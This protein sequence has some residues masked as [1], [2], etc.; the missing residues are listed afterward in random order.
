MKHELHPSAKANLD[1][2]GNA[3]LS[4]LKFRSKTDKKRREFKPDLHIAA[5]LTEKDILS[6]G[7][8]G[9]IDMTGREKARY[10]LEENREVG[11]EGDA[12]LEF[13]RLVESIQ[14]T[15]T[16]S[17]AISQDRL[18]EV[19]F[20]WFRD[21]RRLATYATLS[22]YIYEICSR[23]IQS[24]EVA[25]PI[26]TLS[27]EMPFVVGRVEIRPLTKN[28]LDAWFQNY[29]NHAGSDEERA[30]II[31]KLDR[32]RKR[33]QGYSAAFI[34][35]N[36][37]PTRAQEV[38]L[39]ETEA[40]L[41]ILRYC[42]PGNLSSYIQCAAVP[43]GKE[44]IPRI[45]IFIFKD[46]SLQNR[47]ERM[48]NPIWPS[49]AITVDEI[50]LMRANHLDALSEMYNNPKTKFHR[51]II[52]SVLLY[53]RM[54]VA[55]ELSDK[56]VLL[57]ASL[58]SLFLRNQ[59]EPIQQNLGYRLAQIAGIEKSEKKEIVTTTLRVYNLR[60]KF[61]HH[62]Q[63]IDDVELLNKFMVYAWRAIAITISKRDHFKS[64][65]DYLE[66]IDELKFAN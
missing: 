55:L 6:V 45:G 53:S 52:D 14:R 23:D 48:V 32:M 9:M 51:Q 24:Y 56:L 65:D 29:I 33:L 64:L 35:V 10:F 17:E 27:V 20:D 66:K 22:D 41:G 43:L 36:A 28:V 3:L 4:R 15:P 42:A 40:A 19:A 8:A 57:L 1:D 5:N 7:H 12:Y 18:K 38:A 63:A 46:G 31:A 59:N 11:L 61:V 34:V 62:G 26:A 2:R 37:E 44:N 49:W 60:S 54:S 25:I 30:A 13:E 39:Q 21:S 16:F 50:R 47:V 58:E